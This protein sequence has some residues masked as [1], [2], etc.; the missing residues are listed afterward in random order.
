MAD[1]VVR[2]DPVLDLVAGNPPIPAASNCASDRKR[3]G[4]SRAIAV[5]VGLGLA[6]IVFAYLFA[7][8]VRVG[9]GSRSGVRYRVETIWS[10][11]TAFLTRQGASSELVIG[12]SA[13]A[14]LSILG[15]CLLVGT[16]FAIRN[17]EPDAD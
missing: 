11:F 14:V 9:A 16:A 12:V 3:A 8:S 4:L 1:I 13:L 17:E 10:D 7:G 2:D 6:A 15:S 5:A